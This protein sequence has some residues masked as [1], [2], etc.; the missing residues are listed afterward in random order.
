MIMSLMQRRTDWLKLCRSVEE[1][2]VARDLVVVAATYTAEPI[3]PYLGTRL[4]TDQKTPPVISIGQYNQLFQLCHNWQAM[5]QDRPPSAIVLLWRIE[6]LVRPDFHAVL[7]GGDAGALLSKIEEL[8]DA[9]ATLRKSFSGI[10]VCA[11][12]PFPHSADH[13]IRTL[14]NASIVGALHRKVTDTWVARMREIENIGLLDIDGLQRFAGIESTLDWRK[15]YL[16][17]QPYTEA[18]WDMIGEAAASVI[19]AQSTAS[20]KCVVV[21]CDNT[22]W[23]GIIGEDGLSGIA[24]GEDHPGSIF[25]DFQQQLLT[26]RSKGVMIALC[27]KNN[28]ADVWEVFQKHDGMVLKQDDIV[29]ARINWI[30]KP[31][32]IASLAEELNIGLDSFVF[33]DDN[34]M[35]IEHVRAALPMVTCILVPT[36]LASFPREFGN[37]RGFDREKVSN[38]DRARSDMMLQE[39]KRRDLSTAVSPE[40]FRRELKLSIDLFEVQ[41][42]HIARV[43]QLINK[44]NQFNLT[45]RRKT[46]S[47]IRNLIEDPASSVL[48]WR[49]ADRFGDYGLV[50]VAILG[51][52]D[53]ATDIETLLMSCRVLGRGV[54]RSI[55]AAICDLVAQKGGNRLVGT[56]LKTNKN[57][58]VENLY[59]DYGFEKTSAEQFIL[60]NLKSISWP[61]E[62]ERLGL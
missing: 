43:T 44:S 28:E 23:G 10:I 26:L 14:D 5:Y 52:Q 16:Y 29:A 7:R 22:L 2:E 19:R 56:Y 9:V 39:R 50:G 41:P 42:E 21:D 37:Y 1:A 15:W 3:A 60:D 27:S 31:S 48:A 35:E 33:V 40:E 38:E 25:R 61:V 34:P 30:D 17:H 59:S 18:F 55:F 4:T 32:N 8:A 24:L 13:D 45:T 54:E 20:K 51:H 36:E 12:P 58:L 46:E 53:A 62:I 11:T 49:V 6:D 47:D 57:Q